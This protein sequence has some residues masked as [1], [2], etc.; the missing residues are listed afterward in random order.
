[1]RADTL[2]RSVSLRRLAECD[3]VAWDRR[4]S[5]PARGDWWACC[6][7]HAESTPSFHV[8][9]PH[10]V[11]GRFHCFGCGASGSVID[12]VMARQG[13]DSAEAIRQLASREGLEP[14]REPPRRPELEKARRAL[15]AEEAARAYRAVSRASDAWRLGRA[16]APEL[17]RYLRARGV[18]VDALATLW[19]EGV[20]PTLRYV[21]A[22]PFYTPHAKRPAHVGPA[23]VARVGRRG[24]FRGVHRTWITPEGRARFADGSKV[25][26]KWLGRPGAMFGAPVCLSPAT[27]R[28]VVG[29]GIETT[30]AVLADLVAEGREGWS[31]EAALSLGALAGPQARH[32][33]GPDSA[34]T[35]RPL[36]SPVP[37]LRR[38]AR[39]WTPPPGVAELVVLAEG[40]AAD[41]EAAERHAMRA[42]A[43]LAALGFPARLSPPPGGWA[44]PRDAADLMAEELGRPA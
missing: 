18:D 4:R 36:P 24:D 39:G 13:V 20:P 37:D 44:D 25:P 34:A 41:P 2:K 31:A 33:R 16:H 10:G 26:K 7:F 9:E 27:P 6:P 5:N 1:M 43:K 23:M 8:T 42:Q 15:E 21:D 35:G 28:M 40:S 29:E 11:G 14:G 30:L 12:F 3:G 22:L 17:A 38:R 19:P 32:G